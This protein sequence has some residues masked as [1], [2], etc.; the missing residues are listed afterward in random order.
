MQKWKAEI[1]NSSADTAYMTIW[2]VGI[3]VQTKESSVEKIM[4]ANFIFI[5]FFSFLL[6][7]KYSLKEEL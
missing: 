1:I 5:Y 7:E 3:Q 2:A 6:P 4:S